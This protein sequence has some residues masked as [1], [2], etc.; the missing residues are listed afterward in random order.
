MIALDPFRDLRR[1]ER[2]GRAWARWTFR[3]ARRHRGRILIAEAEGEPVG[4][5]SVAIRPMDELEKLE[6]R[7]LRLGTIMDLFVVPAARGAGVGTALVRESERY[8]SRMG[9]DRVYLN[10]FAPNRRAH[11]LY[12]SLG[13]QEEQVRLRKRVRRPPRRP[14][15]SEPRVRR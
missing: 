11:A 6:S 5:A 7:P 1:T 15:G 9:C 8:L 10:V 3:F 12:R 14:D 13:Y 4:F 2:Y